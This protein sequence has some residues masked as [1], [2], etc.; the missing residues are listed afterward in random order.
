MSEETV[1]CLLYERHDFREQYCISCQVSLALLS[2]SSQKLCPTLTALLRQTFFQL[3]Y[4]LVGAERPKLPAPFQTPP[5]QAVW[6]HNH[7]YFLSSVSYQCLTADLFSSLLL[8]I[9]MVS[10]WKCVL[11]RKDFIHE[12]CS[13][14]SWGPPLN[15]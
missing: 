15:R 7:M 1:G 6:W 13:S 9:E 14:R 10:L 4:S 8:H 2:H 11:S 3:C 5:L 12:R